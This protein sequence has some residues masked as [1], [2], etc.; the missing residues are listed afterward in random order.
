MPGAARAAMPWRARSC[1]AGGADAGMTADAGRAAGSVMMQSGF[2][3]G[4]TAFAEDIRNDMD[5]MSAR[6]IAPDGK[7]GGII[8]E[9]DLRVYRVSEFSVAVEFCVCLCG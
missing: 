3:A 1:A 7:S 6:R 5:G 4:R 8:P 2:S 9:A